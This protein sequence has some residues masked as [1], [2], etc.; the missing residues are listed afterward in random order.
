MKA[1]RIVIICGI[2]LSFCFSFL[3]L[4]FLPLENE[5][6]SVYALQVG[7]YSE[8]DNA[9]K[10]IKTLKKQSLNGYSY[11]KDENFIV[12]SDILLDKESATKLGNDIASK[13]IT[14]LIKEYTVNESYKD[15][16]NNKEFESILKEF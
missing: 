6:M 3:Y 13:G 2:I 8:E 7:I 5:M 1:K 9:E 11:Q 4:R 12:V 14:C 15:Q 16:V 10:M